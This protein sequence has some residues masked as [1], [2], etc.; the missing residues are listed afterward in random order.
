MATESKG[1]IMEISELSKADREAVMGAISLKMASVLR[2]SKG[3]SNSA[4]AELRKA[5][6]DALSLLL[7]RFR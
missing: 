2:A 7:V 1:R 5:E 6:Y 3:E 4:V